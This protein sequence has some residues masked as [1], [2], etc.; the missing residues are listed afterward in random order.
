M[1]HRIS[2]WILPD[3][4]WHECRPWEHIA[5]AK[6]MPWLQEQRLKNSSLDEQWQDPDEEKIRACLAS[7]G[8]IKVCYHMVDADSFTLR[9]LKTLQTVYDLIP[10]ES[11]IEFIGRIRIKIELRMLLKVRDPERLNMLG[12]FG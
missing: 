12:S 9:Q 2:G 3:G 6:S 7:L 8:M 1:S 11:E 10:L 5:A 4:T